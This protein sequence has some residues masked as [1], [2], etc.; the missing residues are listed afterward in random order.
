MNYLEHTY[1][2]DHRHDAVQLLVAD[3]KS[4]TANKKDQAIALYL[5]IRDGWR[6]NP[7][8]ISL[9]RETYRASSIAL[10]TEGHCIEKAILLVAG[11]RALEIPAKLQLAK[12]KNHI[13]VDRLIE[14]FGT[15]ELSPHGMVN[16][17]LNGKWLKVSP[18]FNRQL[19][20]RCKVD[21]I[22]FD[23]ENDSV[24]QQ[25]NWQGNIF[26]EYIEDYGSFEDVPIDFIFN[27]FREHYPGIYEK[28]EG[29]KEIS[30]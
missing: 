20:E 14:K 8:K 2:L 10:K 23:G 4:D 15:N 5:K 1:F 25:Y 21:P 3:Y 19:C 9:D 29:K 12:V 28:N 7:Y 24:F 11:L 30:L 13:G 6:Y 18:A 22:D 17:F 16:L 27:N 26:M